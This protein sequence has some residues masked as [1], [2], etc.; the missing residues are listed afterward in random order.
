MTVTRIQFN[1]L[2]LITKTPCTHLCLYSCEYAGCFCCVCTKWRSFAP[3]AGGT[4]N[5]FPWAL[6]LSSY[7]ESVVPQTIEHSGFTFTADL[8]FPECPFV[9]SKIKWHSFSCAINNTLPT[10]SPKSSDKSANSQTSPLRIKCDNHTVSLPRSR[11]YRLFSSTKK[12]ENMW[13]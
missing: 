10:L 2:M 9:T 3:H 12:K 8:T 13:E 6:L 7:W 5:A 11:E 1:H 4:V